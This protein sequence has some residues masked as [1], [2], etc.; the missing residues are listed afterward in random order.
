MKPIGMTALT[1]LVQDALNNDEHHC[2]ECPWNGECYKIEAN[3]DVG[4]T[5]GVLAK[6]G[7]IEINTRKKKKVLDALKVLKGGADGKRV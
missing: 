4:I 6:K 5:L 1:R 7:V 3:C 2:G